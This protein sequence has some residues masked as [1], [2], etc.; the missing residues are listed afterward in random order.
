MTT[1]CELKDSA[2]GSSRAVLQQNGG[3]LEWKATQKT[4]PKAKKSHPESRSEKVV[5]L[6]CKSV[7]N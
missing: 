3:D 4:T 7:S 2:N 5:E 1:I 6:C